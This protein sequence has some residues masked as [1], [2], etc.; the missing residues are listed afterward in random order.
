ML[1][2]NCYGVD[3]DVSLRFSYQAHVVPR[4]LGSQSG[5]AGAFEQSPE[6]EKKRDTLIQWVAGRLFVAR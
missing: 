6:R 4:Y 1:F 3:R 2:Q 5:S